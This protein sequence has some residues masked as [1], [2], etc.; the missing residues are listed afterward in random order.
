MTPSLRVHS[1]VTNL[2]SR[3]STFV[4]PHGYGPPCSRSSTHLYWLSED[5]G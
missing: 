1:P 2:P 3:S 5:S 4:A